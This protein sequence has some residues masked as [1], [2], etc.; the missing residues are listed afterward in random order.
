MLGK[1]DEKDEP[2]GPIIHQL[3]SLGQPDLNENNML[4]VTYTWA[5]VIEFMNDQY[6]LMN[7]RETEWLIEKQQ[8]QHK[9]NYLNSQIMAHENINKDLV[10]RIKMLEYA[11]RQER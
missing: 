9:T 7:E 11:L 6:K 5:G 10:K 2:T 3:G 1:H 4:E 8:Y